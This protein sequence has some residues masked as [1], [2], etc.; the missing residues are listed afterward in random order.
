M[1]EQKPAASAKE[2]NA[3]E[4]ASDTNNNP[5]MRAPQLHISYAVQH[6]GVRD[7]T[8]RYVQGHKKSEPVDL[9]IN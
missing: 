6:V 5:V 3:K 1:K 7:S 2:A 8:V 9:V 4:N